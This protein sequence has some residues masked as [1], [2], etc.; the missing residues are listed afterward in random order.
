MCMCSRR[1]APMATSSSSHWSPLPSR[2]MVSQS[3]RAKDD[4]RGAAGSAG[5]QGA[6]VRGTAS[7][8]PCVLP[9]FSRCLEQTKMA[10]VFHTNVSPSADR[11]RSPPADYCEE[12][13]PLRGNYRIVSP[14][15]RARD[16]CTGASRHESSP[17][18]VGIIC[19]GS[20]LDVV[21]HADPGK[22]RSLSYLA[23]TVGVARGSD[24][25]VRAKNLSDC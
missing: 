17:Y 21:R 9:G 23:R 3:S 4:A 25:G 24:L 8:A 10:L 11:V 18:Y 7:A 2:R 14:A 20:P 6:G 16:G 5:V 19:A 13:R 1:A 15:L 12:S 22:L